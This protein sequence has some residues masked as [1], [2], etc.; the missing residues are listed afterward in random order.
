MRRVLAIASAGGHWDQL[1]RLRPAFD[2]QKVTYVTTLDGIAQRAGL[3]ARL[4]PD[5]NRNEYRKMVSCAVRLAAILVV[6]R[7]Q[8][9]ITTGALPGLIACA[10]GRL[11]GAKSL[12]I[13]S[14]ANG[15]ELS[16]SGYKA[17]SVATVCLSQWPEV[18]KQANVAHWGAV[19]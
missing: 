11:I 5:C 13:D 15:E 14:I 4:V 3:T 2:D 17:R 1:M 6:V 12:W 9:I 8:L 7:P 18:A 19:L 16:M 10:F